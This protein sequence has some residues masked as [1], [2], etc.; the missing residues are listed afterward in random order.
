MST[1]SA[2]T[3]TVQT[4]IDLEWMESATLTTPALTDTVRVVADGS[5]LKD[6]KL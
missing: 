5:E 4:F 3:A 2:T 6:F 1:E